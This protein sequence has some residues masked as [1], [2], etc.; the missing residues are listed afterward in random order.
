MAKTL[1]VKIMPPRKADNRLCRSM[2][3]KIV[4]LFGTAAGYSSCEANP[5][6]F[7]IS[8][9]NDVNHDG[10]WWSSVGDKQES[11]L[12]K[13]LLFYCGTIFYL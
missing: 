3:K 4:L 11:R 1:N 8:L 7:F 6:T 2:K 5:P 12:L 10:Q 9:G 13:L